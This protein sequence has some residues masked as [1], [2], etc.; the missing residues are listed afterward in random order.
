MYAREGVYIKKCPNIKSLPDDLS[1]IPFMYIDGEPYQPAEDFRAAFEAIY[2]PEPTTAE[3][4]TTFE[5]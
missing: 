2:P 3:Q 1:T 4:G 5:P